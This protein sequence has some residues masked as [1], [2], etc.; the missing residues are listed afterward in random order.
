MFVFSFSGSVLRQRLESRLA[1]WVLCCL[2]FTRRLAVLSVRFCVSLTD[3][4][5]LGHSPDSPGKRPKVKEG[6]R[7]VE[8]WDHRGRRKSSNAP[9]SNVLNIKGH[10][11]SSTFAVFYW[12][13]PLILIRLSYL[14]KSNREGKICCKWLT[15]IWATCSSSWQKRHTFQKD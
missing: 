15:N 13:I 6:S 1:R 10:T 2:S 12:A 5:L 11:R 9:L 14:K 7:K 4:C 8:E 3:S